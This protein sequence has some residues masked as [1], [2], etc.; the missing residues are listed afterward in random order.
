MIDK[1]LNAILDAIDEPDYETGRDDKIRNLLTQ[2]KK[3]MIDRMAAQSS[4]SV[5]DII[6]RAGETIHD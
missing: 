5:V 6:Y 4:I 1:Y 3:D 2:F